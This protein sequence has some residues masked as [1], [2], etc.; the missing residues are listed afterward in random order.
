MQLPEKYTR[1]ISTF[2]AKVLCHAILQN[3]I[4]TTRFNIEMPI[5][6][7]NNLV[8]GKYAWI[9]AVEYIRLSNIAL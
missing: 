5:L 2:R 4:E 9:L 1:R 3:R 7:T 8:L 6:K